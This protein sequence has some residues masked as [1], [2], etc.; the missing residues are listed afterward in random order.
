MLDFELGYL[1]GLIVGE[2]SFDVEPLEALK[3]AFGGK[4]Y[5][6]YHHGG[7]R[8]RLWVLGGYDLYKAIPLLHWA[9]PECK[10]RR[11]LE[12]WIERYSL[13][14]ALDFKRG[15]DRF[16]VREVRRPYAVS[17]AA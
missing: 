4:I 6:P 1:V 5:G 10:K 3:H 17:L 8:Y 14:S 11:Q 2:G 9:M 12:R 16:R 13:Y 7:R 15:R